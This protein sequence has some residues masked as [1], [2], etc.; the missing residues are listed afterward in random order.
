MF[1]PVQQR[2]GG[3]DPAG[4]Q[5]RLAPCRPARPSDRCAGQVDDH[6]VAFTVAELAQLAH[7]AGPA[8]EQVGSTQRVAGQHG[9]GVAGVQQLADQRFADEASAAGDQHLL[10]SSPCKWVGRQPLALHA[11][12]RQAIPNTRCRDPNGEQGE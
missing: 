4:E 2:L 1:Q 6:I 10:V 9:D 12:R 7:A 8:V 5:L 11:K 3:G